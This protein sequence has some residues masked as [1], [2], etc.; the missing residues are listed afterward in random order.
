MPESFGI[1]DLVCK[2]FTLRFAWHPA[3]Q[4]IIH[5]HDLTVAGDVVQRVFHPPDYGAQTSIKARLNVTLRG[6]E[7]VRRKPNEIWPAIGSAKVRH[8]VCALPRA[9]GSAFHR[10]V[11]GGEQAT[12]HTGRF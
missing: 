5:D 12:S 2:F 6:Q 9:S 8:C 10:D 11:P 3:A 7:T 1:A 4:P